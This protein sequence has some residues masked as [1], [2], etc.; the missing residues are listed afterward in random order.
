MNLSG[1]KVLIPII[2][3][4]L[5]AAAALA[6]INQT[7]KALPEEERIISISDDKM[8]VALGDWRTPIIRTYSKEEYNDFTEK[9]LDKIK[10]IINGNIE[11][12]VPALRLED[13]KGLLLIHFLNK[14]EAKT[15]PDTVPKIK[16]FVLDSLFSEEEPIV[17]D[18]IF[19]ENQDEEGIYLY[20][21]ESYLPSF[22]E[23][24]YIEVE[25][26]IDGEEYVSVF[27]I[28]VIDD[29]GN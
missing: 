13:G 6:Y 18:D 20:E 4:I 21:V 28:N 3:V 2:V 24:I 19:T 11:G 10:D 17:I 26:V 15:K 5:I 29:R 14:E 16:L 12:D 27:G 9:E 7:T 23:S 22:H 8:M 25:Y 1:K